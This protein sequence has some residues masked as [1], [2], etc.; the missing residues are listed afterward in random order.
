MNIPPTHPPTS[1]K[2]PLKESYPLYNFVKILKA[3]TTSQPLTTTTIVTVSKPPCDPED[4]PGPEQNNIPQ[5][6]E[7]EEELPNEEPNE[8]QTIS[9]DTLCRIYMCAASGILSGTMAYIII[10]IYND[11]N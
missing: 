11:Y 5:G 9:I 4:P 2:N 1:L 10:I 7:I 3:L 8:R 6:Q